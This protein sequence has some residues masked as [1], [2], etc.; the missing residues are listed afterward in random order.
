MPC[1]GLDSI[2]RIS[3]ANHTR[4]NMVDKSVDYTIAAKAVDVMHQALSV[5]SCTGLQATSQQQAH[6]SAIKSPQSQWVKLDKQV[7]KI[8]G[9]MPTTIPELDVVLQ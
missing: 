1:H 5:V 7:C 8:F 2:A 4:C 9:G 6:N 3:I